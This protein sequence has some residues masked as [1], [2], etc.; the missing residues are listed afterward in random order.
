MAELP[1]LNELEDFVNEIPPAVRSKLAWQ[2]NKSLGLDTSAI[3]QLLKDKSVAEEWL[4]FE[5]E[6]ELTQNFRMRIPVRVQ[7]SIRQIQGLERKEATQDHLTWTLTTR[8][9]RRF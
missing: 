3:R 6:S 1:G 4:Q 7:T 5:L 8:S 9:S 2:I